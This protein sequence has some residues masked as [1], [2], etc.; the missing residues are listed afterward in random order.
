MFP[1][2]P[3]ELGITGST[4]GTSIPRSTGRLRGCLCTWPE[5]SSLEYACLHAYTDVCEE[6]AIT[7]G[8]GPDRPTARDKSVGTCT[9]RG[10]DGRVCLT[11]PRLGRGPWWRLRD[12]GGG[13]RGMSIDV[14]YVLNGYSECSSQ[15]NGGVMT[16]KRPAMRLD[17]RKDP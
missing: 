4:P 9:G 3:D 1:D 14:C 12:D 6:D 10:T 15:S 5:T 11:Y 16:R 17:S 2:E 7:R 13:R 8:S